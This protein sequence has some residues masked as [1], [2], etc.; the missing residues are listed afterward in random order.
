MLSP[1]DN[2]KYKEQ[3]IFLINNFVCG[4]NSY[5]FPGQNFVNIEKKNLFKLKKFEYFCYKKNTVATKRAVLF[6]F[7][8]HKGENKCVIILK[9][10]TMYEIQE[11]N[12]FEE[13]YRGSLFDISFDLEKE[14]IVIYDTLMIAG[15]LC[16]RKTF[17]DRITDASEFIHNVKCNISIRLTEFKNGTYELE[18][19]DELF[20]VPNKLP[21]INGINYSAFKWKPSENITF[22]LQ[23][24]ENLENLDIFTTN[25]KVLKKFA[26]IHSEVPEGK[27][28]IDKIK[29][30]EDYKDDCIIDV[31][32]KN[33][34]IDILNVNKIKTFP[35]NIRSIEKIIKIKEEDLK[36]AE[37]VSCFA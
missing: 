13:Y 22:S 37:L 15:N 27:E 31:N 16:L 26:V 18:E 24:K 25:F 4:Y 9:D 30:L 14:E 1:V 8:D 35:N 33:N 23:V 6:T 17:V 3:V 34:L 32:I 11:I 29:G 36:Y 19:D 20:M 2:D 21:I 12:L 7:I 5:T 10:F 28:Y